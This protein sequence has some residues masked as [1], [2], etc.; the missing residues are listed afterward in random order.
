MT[1][2]LEKKTTKGAARLSKKDREEGVPIIMELQ[3]VVQSSRKDD[4][5]EAIAADVLNNEMRN[6]RFSRYIKRVGN[7]DI[8]AQKRV[9]A[10]LLP[11]C[12]RRINDLEQ[13]RYRTSVEFNAQQR[14]ELG[15]KL[16]SA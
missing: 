14:G 3:T 6:H 8:D 11:A 13:R 7:D 2:T 9:V 15:E 4:M 12:F 10:E 1:T 5:V 16:P